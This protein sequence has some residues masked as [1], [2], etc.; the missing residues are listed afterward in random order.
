MSS[1]MTSRDERSDSL[2]F[3]RPSQTGAAHISVLKGVRSTTRDP[4]CVVPL[5]VASYTA[6]YRV[7][8]DVK[9]SAA[10]SFVRRFSTEVQKLSSKGIQSM[11]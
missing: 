5:I 1:Q 10:E 4:L 2:I 7:N 9:A 11:T 6:R 3:Y 8:R